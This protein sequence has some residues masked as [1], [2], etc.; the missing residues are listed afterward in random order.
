M[1]P[2]LVAV[3]GLGIAIA[4]IY[5]LVTGV[6]EGGNGAE[7][8]AKSRADLQRVLREAERE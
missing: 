2:W 6:L 1:R 3:M 8:D 5:A 7:I 4:A